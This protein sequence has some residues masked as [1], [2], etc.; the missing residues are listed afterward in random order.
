MERPSIKE[1]RRL[2]LFLVCMTAGFLLL[3]GR[4]AFID[5]FR[6]EEWQ[7]LAY[8]QQTRDRLI[9][10]KRGSILDRN[11]TGIAQTQTAAAI[12]AVPAQVTDKESTAAKLAEVLELSYEDVL[13]KLEQKV[14][15]V[16]I[17]SKVDMDTAAQIRQLSLPGIKVDEDVERVYPY[18]EMA[19]QVIGFVGKDNQ[20]IVGL[21]AKYEEYLKG[22]QGK[23]LTQTDARGREVGSGQERIPPVDGKNL[24]TTL[25]VV[26]QE[27]AEQTLQKAVESKEAKRGV[28]IVMNPQNGEIYAMANYPSFDLN[29]PFTVEGEENMTEEELTDAR[30][31]MWRNFAINDTYEPGSTFKMFT[32]SAGLEEGVITPDSSFYC[33]GYHIAGDRM[34]KCWRYPRTHGAQTFTQGV[35]NSCNPVF[36]EVAERLGAE[37]FM[38]YMEKFGFTEKTG[39]DLAGEA[40][41]IL[42]KVENVGPVELATMS[43]GQS[44]QIT[45]LQLLRA[46]SAVVNGGYLVTPHFAMG[47]ADEE[48]NLTETFSYEKGEQV[49]SA[50]TSAQMRQILESVVS[51]GTGSKA[52]MEGYAIGGKTATSE[53]LP[54]RSGKYIASFMTFAPADDP[55]V[56]FFVLIDEPQGTYY[57][58]TVAGPVILEL[59]ENVLPY[60]GFLPEYTTEEQEERLTAVP[61]VTGMTA[62]EAKNALYQAGLSADWNGDGGVVVSQLPPAG[63]RVN[64]DTKVILTLQEESFFENTGEN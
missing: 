45:P 28:I 60:L 30:N 14:A 40:V 3:L 54:R 22:E 42:H 44:F 34:I 53:K 55:Q 43:F 1:K 2:M 21:E 33:N 12:S 38:E 8:E 52:A 19:A 9:T 48:G 5:L 62:Q 39:V 46:A 31:Q 32:S 18:S 29:D 50:E 37:T 13:E 51:E 27:Y 61:D 64:K 58:G 47:L 6:A 36:M 49:I 35:Q 17:Q 24:V 41:G 4:L 20:G 63:Q 26:I 57:G 56:M 25:D 10:P 16:R 15:L 23:I 7:E 59:M 11:G